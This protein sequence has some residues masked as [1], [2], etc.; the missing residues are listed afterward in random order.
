MT[1]GSLTEGLRAGM[2]TT[3]ALEPGCGVHSDRRNWEPGGRP[4]TVPSYRSLGEALAERAERTPDQPA[5]YLFDGSGTLTRLTAGE[6]LLR[7]GGA[8]AAL[9]AAGVRARDA[10][11]IGLDTGPDQLAAFYGCCLIGARP[12]LVESP[13]AIMRASAWQARAGHVRRVLGARVLVAA[14]EAVALAQTVCAGTTT[15]LV[16]PPFPEPR[17]CAPAGTA[18]DDLAFV[19]FTSGTT[20]LAKGVTVTHEALF[21]NA[22]A[23]GTASQFRDGDLAAGWLPLFHD[24]GLVGI[25]LVPALHGLPSALLPP[26]IFI[27]RPSRWLW[28]MHHMRAT[29]SASPNFGYQLC[30][31]RNTEADL[32]GLD[33]SAW[34]LAY[35]GSECVRAATLRSWAER[36]AGYGVCPADMFPVYGMAEAVL[37]IAMPEPGMPPSVDRISRE[38]LW[39]EGYACPSAADS[40]AEEVVSVG[41]P[42][43]GY[44]VRVADD[45]GRELPDRDQGQLLV[46]GPS[47][48]RGYLGDPVLGEDARADGWLR[49][50]DLGYR[51]DGHLFVTGRRKDLIIRAGRNYHPEA[52]EMAA[53]TVAGVRPGGVAAVSA[54][55]EDTGTEA[56]VLVVET[57]QTERDHLA[58]TRRAIDSA[59]IAATGVRP[60]AVIF[61][62]P[63]DLPKT[64]SGKVQRGRL[65]ESVRSGMTR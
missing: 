1:A 58:V 36:M 26:G 24:M 63:G 22:R 56:I 51:A 44:Q 28:M 25:T 50:G 21:A 18:L 6:L 46:R 4:V 29:L 16:C 20:S 48:T 2:T 11:M 54:P 31:S 55:Q 64:T 53:A 65:A 45:D 52:F 35:N 47:L 37:A 19:Q 15:R 42:L 43:P 13:I 10:V 49:T 59:V 5:Y 27:L 60:D 14:P 62:E 41:A 12:T 23:I 9:R 32:R 30:L 34:R 3:V 17:Y 8:A 39:R 40:G 33:L 38:L 61:V 57:A 7:A